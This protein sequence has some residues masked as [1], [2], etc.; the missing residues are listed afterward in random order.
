MKTFLLTVSLLLL[1]QPL[2]LIDFLLCLHFCILSNFKI[3][4]CIVKSLIASSK[5]FLLKYNWKKKTWKLFFWAPE[6]GCPNLYTGLP[7]S[8]NM[9]VLCPST[10]AGLCISIKDKVS[11][12]EHH[13]STCKGTLALQLGFKDLK[14][15]CYVG[16]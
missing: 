16:V 2:C 7:N 13:R 15:F 1:V 4:R 6:F 14:S 5:Y 8:L 11:M 9:S 10:L 3:I 12:I